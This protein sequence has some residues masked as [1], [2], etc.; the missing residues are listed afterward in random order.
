MNP[1]T[2][3]L[4]AGRAVAYKVN[5]LTERYLQERGAS[6]LST[7]ALHRYALIPALMWTVLFVRPAD[8]TSILYTPHQVLYFL[9]IFLIW[10][11]QQFAHSFRVNATSTVSALSNLYN[12]LTLPLLLVVGTLFNHDKANALSIAGILVLAMAMLIQPA[13]HLTNKRARLSRPLPILVAFICV[14]AMVDVVLIALSRQ[15]LK[16]IPPRVFI[17][18]FLILVLSA[19]VVCV[20]LL[21]RRL[22][23][24]VRKMASKNP[25][26]TISLPLIFFAGAVMEFY[27]QAKLPI[28]ILI[29][30]GAI[31]FV[32][33]ICSD[34]WRRRIRFNLQTATFMILV[35]IGVGLAVYAT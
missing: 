4:A 14:E 30:I 2:V 10:N 23:L 21:S 28:Y 12:V 33:D 24:D 31:T 16:E 1:T 3:F 19:C 34:L 26:R 17:G 32:M 6:P 7:Y 11:A 13:H 27:A 18:V 25:G 9:V 5:S 29:S 8:I 20:Q 22:P 15:L 35:F